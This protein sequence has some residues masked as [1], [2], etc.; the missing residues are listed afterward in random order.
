MLIDFCFKKSATFYL[1]AVSEGM[2]RKAA[3]PAGYKL[4]GNFQMS[5]GGHGP[6][7]HIGR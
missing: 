3:K 2:I 6:M 4:R 7:V 5:P 1:T